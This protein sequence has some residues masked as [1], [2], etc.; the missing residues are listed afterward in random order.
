MLLKPLEMKPWIKHTTA[1][2]KKQLSLFFV[3]LS[4]NC[5]AHPILISVCFL[6]LTKCLS[7]GVGGSR[8]SRDPNLAHLQQSKL[9]H[10]AT[11]V[12]CLEQ[13]CQEHTLDS[14][15]R[16]VLQNRLTQYLLPVSLLKN[17]CDRCF[18]ASC[19]Y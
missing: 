3:E 9:R 12:H 4:L 5:V 18:R 16:S 13:R 14:R 19:K 8:H 17:V 7:F 1:R 10:K 15:P 2:V 6:S 11:S